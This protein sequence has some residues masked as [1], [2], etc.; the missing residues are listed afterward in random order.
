MYKARGSVTTLLQFS[1]MLKKEV[2][3]VQFQEEPISAP[4]IE[5]W[6]LFGDYVMNAREGRDAL[7]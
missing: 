4:A 2:W 3:N 1:I 7:R 5:A 6:M